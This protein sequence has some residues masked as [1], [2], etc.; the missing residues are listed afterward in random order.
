MDSR[1]AARSVEFPTPFGRDERKLV[2][3]YIAS[4]V[5][6]VPNAVTSLL[7]DYDRLKA[8]GGLAM[9]IMTVRQS[10]RFHARCEELGL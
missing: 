8:R 10:E 2:E 6:Q 5:G 3:T 7:A 9:S 4:R 1:S